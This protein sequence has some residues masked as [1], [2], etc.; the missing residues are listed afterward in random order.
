MRCSGF[1]SRSASQLVS[2]KQKADKLKCGGADQLLSLTNKGA[3]IK[4]CPRLPARPHRLE[5]KDIAL[6]RRKP[7]FESRWGHSFRSPLQGGL[8]LYPF[9]GPIINVDYD[10]TGAGKPQRNPR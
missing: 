7:G 5:A 3:S 4:L 8:F 1:P 10:S 6:S 2:R 9:A